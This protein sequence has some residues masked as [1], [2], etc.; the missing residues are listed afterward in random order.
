MYRS[1]PILALVLCAFAPFAQ[2]QTCTPYS[3]TEWLAD[4]N[5]VDVSMGSLDLAAASATLDTVRGRVRC[6]NAVV[7]PGHMA[8]FSRQ[9][10]LLFYFLQDTENANAWAMTSKTSAP[11][12]P[13][14]DALDASHPFH[15]QVDAVPMPEQTGPEGHYYI[16]PKK[17]AVFANG[18]IQS[19]PV[20]FAETPA[21]FQ[22][23]DKRGN[24]VNAWWQDG[25]AFPSS[26]V[27]T[28][29]SVLSA[30]KWWEGP[31]PMNV[32]LLASSLE[33]HTPDRPELVREEPVPQTPVEAVSDPIEDVIEY[34]DDV[35][36]D[37]P[38]PEP[39][40]SQELP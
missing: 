38:A 33:F 2:A 6:L 9:I 16:V 14:P 17:G 39:G 1:A 12:L 7:S 18:R 35:S 26:V 24:L 19:T 32:S 15:A 36:V 10:S 29:G 30:T 22:V 20:S 21:L 13:W 31:D 37:D 40:P 27:T 5:T 8:R 34:V 3:H 25:V 4:M 11:D 23:T 28:D